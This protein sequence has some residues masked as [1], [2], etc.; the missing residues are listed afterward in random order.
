MTHP[1]TATGTDDRQSGRRTGHLGTGSGVFI[2]FAGAAR[3]IVL[4]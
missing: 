4:A 2:V 1:V 3:V